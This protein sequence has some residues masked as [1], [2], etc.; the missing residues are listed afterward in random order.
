MGLD[1]LQIKRIT[2]N[3]EIHKSKVLD[4][5]E[6]ILIEDTVIEE[7][8]LGVVPMF[9][10]GDGNS[11]ISKLIED[12]KIF[13]NLNQVEN[14]TEALIDTKI[15]SK[16]YTA[17]LE[18]EDAIQP[19]WISG[20]RGYAGKSQIYSNWDHTHYLPREAIDDSLA[21]NGRDD[22]KNDSQIATLLSLGSF[23]CRRIC[24]GTQDP[25][26]YNSKAILGDIYIKY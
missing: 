17:E 23:K 15:E 7:L 1:S 14:V 11:T 21:L 6:P 16:T 12:H 10:V 25:N 3:Y 26:T 19:S 2:N 13:I 8:G 24:A 22:A 4:N 5:G 20:K 18:D 9:V